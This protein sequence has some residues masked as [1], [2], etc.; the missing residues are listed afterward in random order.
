[1]YRQRAW[2]FFDD[3]R[4][5]K[6]GVH[7]CGFQDFQA[8]ASRMDTKEYKS[9]RSRRQHLSAMMMGQSPSPHREDL[10]RGVEY[11]PT[12]ERVLFWN[13]VDNVRYDPV[14]VVKDELFQVNKEEVISE[15]DDGEIEQAA[16]G[17]NVKGEC[18][19]NGFLD[20]DLVQTVRPCRVVQF[21]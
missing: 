15:S 4:L 17:G 16:D 20:E 14:P 1:M 6:D 11:Y 2:A 8:R 18:L 3:E 5:F 12:L 10:K 7:L 19:S 13:E 21:A 9:R